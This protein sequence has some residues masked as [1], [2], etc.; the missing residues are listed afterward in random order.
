MPKA[1]AK[2][3]MAIRP[4][5]KFRPAKPSRVLGSGLSAHPSKIEAVIIW[6]GV[7][8]EVLADEVRT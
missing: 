7:W 8:N 3:Y 6:Q 5:C 1:I 4:Y 2:G